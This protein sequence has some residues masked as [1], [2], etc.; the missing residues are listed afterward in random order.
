MRIKPNA[1]NGFLIAC[2]SG[3]IYTLLVF[4]NFYQP[5]PREFHEREFYWSNT[6]TTYTFKMIPPATLKG[7]FTHPDSTNALATT[8]ELSESEGWFFLNTRP[9]LLTWVLLFTLFNS[10]CCGAFYYLVGFIRATYKW[11]DYRK[12]V[13]AIIGLS[14]A[15]IVMVVV[16]SMGIILPERNLIPPFNLWH[17]FPEVFRSVRFLLPLI[18]AP[19]YLLGLLCI[20]TMIL[21]GN[22]QIQNWG[23]S[24]QKVRTRLTNINRLSYHLL[25]ILSLVLVITVLTSFFMYQASQENLTGPKEL[26]FPDRVLILYGAIFTF[27]ILMIYFPTY[28]KVKQLNEDA[29]EFA[30]QKN[31]EEKPLTDLSDNLLKLSIPK[32]LLTIASPVITSLFPVLIEAL[33]GI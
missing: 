23:N 16:L 29:L 30:R 17:F 1:F 12:N 4:A 28:F 6:D 33:K 26:L 8:I 20:V 5:Q 2:F 14:L 9:N 24:I 25:V 13:V 19:G 10:F 11:E 32:L 3:I 7:C 15:S 22:T 27:F 18:Q 21:T 31:W